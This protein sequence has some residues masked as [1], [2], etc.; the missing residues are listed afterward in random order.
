M[1]TFIL[2]D[3]YGIV[4]VNAN[5]KE[6]AFEILLQKEKADECQVLAFNRSAEDLI[7]L[8]PNQKGIIAY[9]AE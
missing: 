1:K 4:I 2:K 8:N 5:S 3:G 9:Y 6:E 7:E